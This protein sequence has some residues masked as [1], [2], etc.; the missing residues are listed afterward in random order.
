M[1]REESQREDLIREAT[2]L[3]ERIEI[4]FDASVSN[5]PDSPQ[6]VIIGFRANGALSIFFGEDPVYQF[7]SAGDLRRAYWNGQL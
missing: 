6:Q 4:S 2:A 3:V 5:D 1:S 7:N